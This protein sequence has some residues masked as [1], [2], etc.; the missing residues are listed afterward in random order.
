M[1]VAENNK[2]SVEEFRKLMQTTDAVLNA[3]AGRNPGYYKN[4]GGTKL[5]EDVFKAL[6]ACAEN[7]PFE[8]SIELVSGHSFPDIITQQYYG[9]EVKSTNKNHWTSI[10]SSILESTRAP[11]V[12]RIFLTFGKL[13]DPVQFISRP[14]EECMA[15][16]AVTHYP[17]YQIDM[18]LEAGKTI[19]DALHIS[20][21]TLRTM[22]NPVAP[23]SKYYRSK[24]KEGESLWWATEYPEDVV[25]PPVIR[26]WNTLSRKEKERLIVQGYALFPEIFGYG[27]I[28]YNRITTWLATNYSILHPH[29]RDSFSAGGK[30]TIHT[31]AHTYNDV[32]AIYGRVLRYRQ[33]IMDTI[34]ESSEED[35]MQ[36]WNVQCICEDRTEQWCRCVVRYVSEPEQIYQLLR[37]I[38]SHSAF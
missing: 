10:G 34:L 24:L 33:Q 20:Y 29:I 21:D 19:F 25:S 17:R 6:C 8:G 30:K 2:P 7:T 22:E 9:V 12:E 28:K 4:R 37:D 31:A 3:E 18:Q 35:L 5:E 16:I 1:I 32:P 23:V 26:L 15:G 36:F 11:S 13:A 38:F 14:Y 27:T